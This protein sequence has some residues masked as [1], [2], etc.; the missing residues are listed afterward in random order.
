MYYY[1]CTPGW[2]R[3]REKGLNEGRCRLRPTANKVKNAKSINATGDHSEC[4]YQI[5]LPW[6]A[7]QSHIHHFISS[8]FRQGSDLSTPYNY[9]YHID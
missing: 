7:R 8:I 6:Q 4:R 5:L 9:Y 2:T 1:Y 3:E